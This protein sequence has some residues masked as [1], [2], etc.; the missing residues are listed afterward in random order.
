MRME[1]YFFALFFF[2][3]S[4]YAT[5][6]IFWPRIRAVW[7]GSRVKIGIVSNIGIALVFGVG[8]F[9]ML[10]YAHFG[11]PLL[12]GFVCAFV[13]QFLDFRKRKS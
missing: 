8:G 12:L 7:R 9:V 10:G 3:V 13:G 4:A 6:G 2:G 1:K 11:I 5:A